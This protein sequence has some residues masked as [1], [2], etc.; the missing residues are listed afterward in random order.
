MP[1]ILNQGPVK[2]TL[3]FGSKQIR[4]KTDQTGRK[5]YSRILMSRGKALLFKFCVQNFSSLY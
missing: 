3:F 4:N 1:T 2:V 5:S